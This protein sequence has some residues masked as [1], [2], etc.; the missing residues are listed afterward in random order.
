MLKVTSQKFGNVVILRCQGKFVR[1]QEAAVLLA[2]AEQKRR[3]VILDLSQVDAI[4]AGGLG[5]LLSLR[6][7]GICL[8]LMDPI[9]RVREILSLTRLDSIFKICESEST[10]V[11]LLAIAR[12]GDKSHVCL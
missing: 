7:A 4:D 1:G 3:D 9:A 11:M 5:A 10:D 2:A 12:A 6:A 8:K